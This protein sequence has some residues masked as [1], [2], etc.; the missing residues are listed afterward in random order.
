MIP[1]IYESID[2]ANPARG[3]EGEAMGGI[4]GPGLSEKGKLL[5]TKLTF[6]RSPPRQRQQHQQQQQQQPLERNREERCEK[7][8]IKRFPDS[9]IL[10]KVF[11]EEP[12]FSPILDA[13][14]KKS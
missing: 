9:R 11:M 14:E 13:A 10:K 3:V 2:S 5:R 8:R 7:C 4:P 1:F 12:F 6:L